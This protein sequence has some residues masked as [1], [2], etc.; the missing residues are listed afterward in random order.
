MNYPEDDLENDVVNC[1]NKGFKRYGYNVGFKNKG[2]SYIGHYNGFIKQLNVKGVIGGEASLEYDWQEHNQYSIKC[3][4]AI[5]ILFLDP[6]GQLGLER[7]EDYNY[8]YKSF[9]IKILDGKILYIVYKAETKIEMKPA[10]D[11]KN[12]KMKID[13]MVDKFFTELIGDKDLKELLT[14]AIT[15]SKVLPFLT[16]TV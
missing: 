9:Y 3:E 5:G 14:L 11:S 6:F 4:F 7:I 13:K 16:G 10:Y 8:E 1:L 15:E 12:T 2:L